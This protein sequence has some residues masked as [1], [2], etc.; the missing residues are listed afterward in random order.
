M[1]AR[2]GKTEWTTSIFPEKASASFLLP[3]KA[4]VRR[5]ERLTAGQAIRINLSL[6]RRR[7]GRKHVRSH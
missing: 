6:E 7:M 5:K 2:T 3:V 4:E 1:I